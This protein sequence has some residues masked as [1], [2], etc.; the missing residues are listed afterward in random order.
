MP[1]SAL[2]ARKQVMTRQASWAAAVVWAMATNSANWADTVSYRF[3][4]LLNTPHTQ[5]EFKPY[6]IG[7]RFDSIENIT[8]ELA[9]EGRRTPGK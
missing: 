7:V 8:F 9:G 4:D 5:I 2:K 1:A 6:D 3:D